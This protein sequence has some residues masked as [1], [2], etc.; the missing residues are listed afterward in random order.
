L[1]GEPAR[2]SQELR[3][4]SRFVTGPDHW[5]QLGVQAAIDDFLQSRNRRCCA[6]AHARSLG[7]HP[8]TRGLDRLI[9]QLE[10]DHVAARDSTYSRWWSE[11]AAHAA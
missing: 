6:S 11:A 4:H 3:W 2:H 8:S 5:P 9:L 1:D 7:W 10:G